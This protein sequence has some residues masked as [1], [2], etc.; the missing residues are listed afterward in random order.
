MMTTSDAA[1]RRAP[2]LL[3]APII[4][5][6]VLVKTA[7]LSDDA[8]I[9]LRTVVNW[10]HGFGLVWNV[11]ERVQAYTHPLWMLALSAVHFVSHETYFTTIF[12]SIALSLAAFFILIARLATGPAAAL[13]VAT[14]AIFSKAF[15]DYS[16]SGLENPLTHL[17]LALFFWIYFTRENRSHPLLW[18]ALW[19]GL[20]GVNRLDALLLILP[21]L[22]W[23]AWQAR[24][25]RG[26]AR[27]LL[28]GFTPLIL[29]ELFALFYYGFPFPNTAYAKLNTGLPMAEVLRQGSFYLF[30]SFGSD[31][32]TVIVLIVGLLLPFVDALQ[33]ESTTRANRMAARASALG[34]GLYL[35]YI[36]W[37][38]GDFMMGRFL[39]APFFCALVIVA[40]QPLDRRPRWLQGALWLGI[41][42]IGLWNPLQAPVLSTARYDVGYVDAR[43][44]ADERGHYYQ[45]YGLLTAN[46]TNRFIEE[47]RVVGTPDPQNFAHCGIGLRGFSASPYTHIVDFCGLTDPLLA[48]LP[49]AYDPD[50]RV[51]HPIRDVPPG[52]LGTLRTGQPQLTDPDLAAFYAHLQTVVRGPLFSR[53]RLREIWRFN[54]GAYAHLIDVSRYRYPQR[55]ELT[56]AALALSLMPPE[57]QPD[58][59]G[60]T[61][62]AHGLRITLETPHTARFL[63]VGLATDLLTVAFERDGVTI[64]KQTIAAAPIMVGGHAY[65]AMTIPA[66]AATNGFDGVTLLPGRGGEQLL[67][68]LDFVG[69][70]EAPPDDLTALVHLYAYMAYRA[71]PADRAHLL[72]D[73][74]AQIMA[75][76]PA[77]WASLP[78]ETV[79]DLVQI[80][81]RAWQQAI[82]AAWPHDLLL[83]TGE[84]RPRLRY[85]GTTDAQTQPEDAY[86]GLQL[87]MT[88]DVLAPFDRDYTMWFHIADN[89]SDAEYMIYDYVP[90]TSTL[91]W[92]PGE[93]MVFSPILQLPPGNYDIS[94]GF[95]TPG[96]R[97]RLQVEDNADVTWINLGARSV[98]QGD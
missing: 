65:T 69:L 95:W 8:F 14:A 1:D 9:T 17:L 34:I 90:M 56:A 79:A 97:R 44:I 72:A 54:R 26:A 58:A 33:P 94:F 4:F 7:W 77:D 25:Q 39:S 64:A 3:L 21:A 93:L 59:G 96:D 29:W 71:K 49:A 74:H 66:E 23:A 20:I 52:Y 18:L 37:I 48:R 87:H 45:R 27:A 50:W 15:V 16:T 5:G 83:S 41:M 68:A 61:F 82:Y 80:P 12:L 10:R 31:P 85:L 98:E 24:K 89:G 51:G 86:Q 19:G 57:D 91:A 84:E 81:D 42:L 60:V 22:A 28:I 53:E 30:H 35:L 47:G 13:L 67:T 36:V 2:L 11:G 38:G 32:L 92:A 75:A 88:F 63:V 43:G 70:T 73:I 55:R 46:R 40:Q 76:S 78:L 6:V 62:N